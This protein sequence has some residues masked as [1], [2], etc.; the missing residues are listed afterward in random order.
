MTAVSTAGMTVSSK[1]DLRFPIPG[2]A[3]RGS[4]IIHF[5]HM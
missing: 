2:Q 3:G 4:Q 5:E 1:T